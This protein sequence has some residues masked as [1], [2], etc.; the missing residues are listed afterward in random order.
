[1][2]WKRVFGIDRLKV[3]FVALAT[4]SCFN[5]L[6]A[7][8][9]TLNVPSTQYPTI[10]SAIDAARLG[11]TIV[12]EAGRTYT[13]NLVLKY[14]SSGSGWITIQS[15]KI[16]L[17]PTEGNRVSPSDAANMPTIQSGD[18]AYSAVETV[19]GANPS[20]HYRF[21]GIDF[22]RRDA[23][24]ETHALVALG[25]YGS[26]QN[27]LAEVPTY[28]EFDRCLFRGVDGRET[29]RGIFNEAQHVK[30]VNSHFEKFFSWSDAQAIL[31]INSPG[32]HLIANNYLEASGE[33]IMYGGGDPSI[34]NLIPTNI[35]IEH[36]HIFKPLSWK[37]NEPGTVKNLLELKLGKNVTIRNNILENS[38]EHGQN[39]AAFVITVRNQDG[40]APWATIQDVL[41]EYNIIKNAQEPYG[42]LLADD[43]QTSVPAKNITF[44][45]NLYVQQTSGSYAQVKLNGSGNA[46][47][48]ENIIID[49]NTFIMNGVG[50]NN[51]LYVNGAGSL[52]GLRVNNN[53]QAGNGDGQGWIVQE[54]P[55]RY[56]TAALNS[57]VTSGNWEYSK[58]VT[59]GP[60]TGGA[61]PHPS[62]SAYV[63]NNNAFGFL[64]YAAGNFELA[65]SSPYKNAGTDGKD[66]GAD[67][68]GLNQR[69]ACVQS[70]KRS[71]C[72]FTAAPSSAHFDF[73]GDGKA[74]TSVF[75]PTDSV[76]YVQKSTGGES[77]IK[78]GI[79]NDKIAPADFDGDGKTDIAVFRASESRWYILRSSDQALSVSFFGGEG[80]IP[81]QADYD[82]DG[83]ADVAIWRPSNGSWYSLNSSNGGYN[84]VRFG[85][86]GDRPAVGDYDGD[87]KS[88]LAIYRPQTGQWYLQ[89]SSSGL[90]V[91]S[92]GVGTDVITPADFDGDGKTDIA[93]FRPSNGIW[94]RLDSSNGRMAAFHFGVSGDIPSVADYD[95]DGMAD[96]ALFRPSNGTWY[97]QNSI[98]GFAAQRF[99]IQG[100]V[101]ISSALLN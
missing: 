90:A 95:G 73:D 44:R 46:T 13:E 20:H 36:N 33:N 100:D 28:F 91:I 37:G 74:D 57:V 55:D 71:D 19:S 63:S 29:R 48:S 21:I 27:T 16:N 80:D 53:I 11:D 77:I 14:K 67:I 47:P 60:G 69:T 26:N 3:I 51:L 62:G 78:W 93:V 24:G 54:N 66:I 39:G 8:A 32:D 4:V 30:I 59:R 22:T 35:V 87:G 58:N 5:A 70:G 10:Q 9:A 76:W 7:E 15:S 65:P 98:S 97:F 99:G 34:P 81:V 31:S 83:K 79:S 75:R 45:N 68:R 25:T 50:H 42:I 12:V 17:L 82:G 101:P 52:R 88:D 23:S 72:G 85:M 2:F 41:I 6:P 1:M 49:H 61:N 43:S 64:N 92:F 40:S 89:R 84:E 56:G 86:Q 18:T 38:W 96:I 94:Y